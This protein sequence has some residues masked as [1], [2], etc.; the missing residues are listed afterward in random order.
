MRY[1]KGHC[2]V[3][4]RSVEKDGK[5]KLLER[6]QAYEGVVIARR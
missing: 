4:D 6:L 5:E 1:C 2:K 3:I